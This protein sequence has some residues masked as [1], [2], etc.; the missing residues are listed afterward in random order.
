MRVVLP[1]IINWH[2]LGSDRFSRPF[3]Y[4][5]LIGEVGYPK[6]RRDFSVNF[7]INASTLVDIYEHERHLD[8]NISLLFEC[9]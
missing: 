7:A 2:P 1:G 8:L 4:K 9:L 5:A 3:E 6:P